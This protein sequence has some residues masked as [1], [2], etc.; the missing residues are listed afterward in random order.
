[1]TAVSSL[2]RFT[3]WGEATKQTLI[4]VGTAAQ[5]IDTLGADRIVISVL[6]ATKFVWVTPDDIASGDAG[7]TL[8]LNNLTTHP[9][10]EPCS[11][12]MEL[13]GNPPVWVT[14]QTGTS[15][16]SVIHFYGDHE[17]ESSEH[18]SSALRVKGWGEDIKHTQISVGSAAHAKLDVLGASRLMIIPIDGGVR[19]FISPT[20]EGANESGLV[21]LRNNTTALRN[22]PYI[23]ELGIAGN[24]PVYLRGSGAG[25]VSVFHF[26][27]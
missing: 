8:H 24:A 1:M 27:N 19:V 16:I 20:D 10:N 6:E 18:N 7:I 22:D 15:K 13:E 25:E 21:A 12:E 26:Y 14:S 4:S 3:G 17:A 5:K 9:R 23:I 2:A 11:V